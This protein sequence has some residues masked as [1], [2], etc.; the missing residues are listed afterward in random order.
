VKNTSLHV[1]VIT[2]NVPSLHRTHL[3]VA[4][5]AVAGGADIIQFRDKTMPD[6]EFRV[7]AQKLLQLCRAQ[8]VP[9][10][11]NDRVEIAVQIGAD[12]IHVGHE[13]MSVLELQRRIPPGMILGVSARNYNEAVALADCGADYLGVG[14]IFATPSKSDAGE[15]IGLDELCRI[16]ETV[17]LPIVAIGG[18]TLSNLPDVTDTGAAG[19]AVISAVTHQPD[20][21]LATSEFRAIWEQPLRAKAK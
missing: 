9:L 18:I 19:A 12:G 6:D 1:Y 10:I 16:C 3:D 8:G 21:T 11:V 5:A 14:P 7:T 2:E 17:K 4:A 13:D 15:P 20:M